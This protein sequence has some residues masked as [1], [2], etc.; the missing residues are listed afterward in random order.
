MA[1]KTKYTPK[2]PNKY[3]GTKSKIT[4]RSLWERSFAKWCDYNDRV[5]EW[6]CEPFSIQ[7]FDKARKKM[8]N[9]FPDFII[10]MNNGKQYLIEI[11]PRAQTVPPKVRKT[12]RYLIEKKTYLTNRCK[13]QAAKKFCEDQN[14]I[15]NIFTEDDFKRL[16]IKIIK[17]LPKKYNGKKK[18]RRINK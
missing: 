5:I 11:K 13:W 3:I 8:R 15:F 4:C 16:G 18:Q 9:Y 12:K 1:Y 2:N 14:I 17:K 6:A 10:K 7:Y